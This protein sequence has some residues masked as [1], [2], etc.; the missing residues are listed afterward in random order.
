MPLVL[1]I[2]Q[3]TTSTKALVVDQT[4]RVVGQSDG[5]AV[6]AHH[7]EPGWVEYDPE[8]ML[9]TVVDAARAAVG[10]AGVGFESIDAV[11]L[12]NQGETSIAFDA[13][14]GAAIHPAISWQDR[15]T[16]ETV[17]EWRER[18]LEDEARATTGLGI[19]SYFSAPKI[20]WILANVGRAIELRPSGRLRAGTS[21]GWLL[22]RLG[23]GRDFVTDAATAS[24]TLLLDLAEMRWSASLADA[25]GVPVDVLPRIEANAGRLATVDRQ[26]FGV[27]LPITG[28]CVDQ[29]AALFGHGCFDAGAAKATYGTGCFLLANVGDD[30]AVRARG[31]LTCVAW[32][33]GSQT[34]YALDGGVYSAGSLVEWFVDIG[35]AESAADVSRLAAEVGDSAGAV[36]IPALAGL[37]APRWQ[38]RARACLA[39]MSHATDRRH[40]ARA[41][42]E[43]IAYRVREIFDAMAEAGVRLSGLNA[44]GGLTGS[45]PL[46]QLQADALGAP[47]HLAATSELTGFGVA[48]LAGLGAGVWPSLASLPVPRRGAVSYEPKSSSEAQAG[49][50]RWRRFC[51][52]VERWGAAGLTG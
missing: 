31:L 47:V 28:L 33:I 45:A 15:R 19:E 50:V 51:D 40:L 32:K 37:A 3:G 38:G 24:R 11:G 17:A 46:M 5:H 39:G 13:S 25:F 41:A 43:A 35:V 8:Q 27:E 26:W 34:S 20:A 30:P 36:L 44:D 10:S 7:P 12:A 1:A 29:Q 4:G 48:L 6:D 23:G 16:E 42:L 9:A 22:W 14:D 2:D 21:D 49:Y 52:E 18:G